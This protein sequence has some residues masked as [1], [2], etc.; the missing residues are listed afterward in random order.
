MISIGQ[1]LSF[2]MSKYANSHLKFERVIKNASQSK[3]FIKL[4]NYILLISLITS[5][6]I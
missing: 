2:L 3:T 5:I 6:F 1:R 4:S